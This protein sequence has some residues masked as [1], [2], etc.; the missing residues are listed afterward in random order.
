MRWFH[1]TCEHAAE[2]ID[3]AGGLITVNPQ[4]VLARVEMSWWTLLPSASRADLGL[5]SRTLRCDRMARLYEADPEDAPLILPW[6]KVR[7]EFGS[8]ALR[9]EAVRGTRAALW[10]IALAPVRVRVG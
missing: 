2:R 1:R 4:P 3:A 5:S 9:L 6:T 10:G 7:S 8:A